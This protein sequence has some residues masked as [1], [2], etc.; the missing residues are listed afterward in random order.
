[1]SARHRYQKTHFLAAERTYQLAAK[2]MERP[3]LFLSIDS[4]QPINKGSIVVT[5]V[6]RRLQVTVYLS[7]VFS[8]TQL[9]HLR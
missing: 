1:M 3:Q 4:T 5:A 9:Q 8:C 2:Q 7:L 6:K